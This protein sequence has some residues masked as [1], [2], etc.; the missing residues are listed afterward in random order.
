MAESFQRFPMITKQPVYPFHRLWGLSRFGL[1]A[2]RGQFV[3]L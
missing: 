1:S 3:D 2:L